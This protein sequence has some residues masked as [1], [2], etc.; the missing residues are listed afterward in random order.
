M[1][2]S[3]N[4]LLEYLDM[5]DADGNIPTPEEIALK[6]N[7]AGI[8]VESVKKIKKEEANLS[9]D[10]TV[11][12]IRVSREL[13]DLSAMMWTINELCGILEIPLA[14]RQKYG[15]L[16]PNS[17]WTRDVLDTELYVDS[18]TDKCKLIAGRIINSIEH[19]KTPIDI[20]DRVIVNGCKA[21]DSVFDLANY[22]IRNLGQPLFLFDKDKLPSLN[23]VIKESKEKGEIIVDSKKY[24]YDEKDLVLTCLDEVIGIGGFLIDDK[25]KV[26][27][28]TKSLLILTAVIGFDEVL[29][30]RNRYNLNDLNCIVAS[31]GSN[32]SSAMK[33]LT[34]ITSLYFEYSGAKG[35]EDASIYNKYDFIKSI[36]FT[37]VKEVN[38]LLDTNYRH[39]DIVP[40][41]A[42]CGI[43][44]TVLEPVY[45]E[46][47]KEL[48][49]GVCETSPLISDDI[50]I[51][52]KFSS[53]R[54]QRTVN[55]FAQ[56]VLSLTG[57]DYIK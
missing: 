42:N 17:M 26:T 3:Y 32:H 13:S 23:I 11:I 39:S 33:E 10:D 12:D 19:L 16:L 20:Q 44:M 35:I 55:D 41:V 7:K 54:N 57:C 47:N 38:S 14:S 48:F 56:T 4:W 28:E 15:E 22:A 6:M 49:F 30:L 45:D 5:K 46:N 43:S 29:K 1:K 40:I 2:I 36:I 27:K 25:Y 34:Y 52:A 8:D 31:A 24:A 53:F 37:S 18:Y 50:K 51:G 9:K 21:I